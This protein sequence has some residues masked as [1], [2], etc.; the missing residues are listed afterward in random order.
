MSDFTHVT[1]APHVIRA[2]FPDLW[3]EG[4]LPLST[5][6]GPPSLILTTPPCSWCPQKQ[7]LQERIKVDGKLNN[8]GNNVTVDLDKHAVVVTSDIPFSKR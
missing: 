6:L 7:F 3:N 1:N 4:H 8:L 2:A 5:R